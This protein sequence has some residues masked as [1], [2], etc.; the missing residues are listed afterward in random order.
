MAAHE[1]LSG[2]TC[3]NPFHTLYHALK[4]TTLI[5]FLSDLYCVTFDVFISSV[6]SLLFISFQSKINNGNVQ[7][8][9]WKYNNVYTISW[10][11]TA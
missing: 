1:M 7:T 9:K 5:I 6:A 2:S 10:R 8:Q 4:G 11:M 3:T